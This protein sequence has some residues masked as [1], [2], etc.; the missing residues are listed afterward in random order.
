MAAP[1]GNPREDSAI[2]GAKRLP[3]R[4]PRGCKIELKRRLEL[5]MAKPSFSTTVHRIFVFFE[6]P[7]P[8]LEFKIGQT[9]SLEAPHEHIIIV[10][11][12]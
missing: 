6:V 9:C 11:A 3:T 4:W 5:K 2:S 8:L 10:K 12:S 7:G 1:R